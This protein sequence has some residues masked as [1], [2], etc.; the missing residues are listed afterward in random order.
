MQVEKQVERLN[1]ARTVAQQLAAE[2][3]RIEGAQ[4]SA[5][6]RRDELGKQCQEKFDCPVSGLGELVEEFKGIAAKE[7]R[8]AE[9]ILG[10]DGPDEA[11]DEDVDPD[12]PLV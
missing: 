5:K 10:I 4:T 2:G 8:Q 7:L 12:G 11:I 1:Q 9:K 6:N 3:S